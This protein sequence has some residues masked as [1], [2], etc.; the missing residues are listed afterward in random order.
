ME[1]A[2]HV[3]GADRLSGKLH[4]LRQ[5][6]PWFLTAGFAERVKDVLSSLLTR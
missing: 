3:S 2:R 1:F 5:P 4:V 6:S